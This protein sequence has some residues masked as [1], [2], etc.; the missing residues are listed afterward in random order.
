MADM[1][2]CEII[3]P[4]AP[5][6]VVMQHYIQLR[7]STFLRGCN[8]QRAGL[9]WRRLWGRILSWT[10]P[11]W[12]QPTLSRYFWSFGSR[13]NNGEKLSCLSC[14]T[15]PDRTWWNQIELRFWNLLWISRSLSLGPR[16]RFLDSVFFDEKTE[17]RKWKCE[18]LVATSKGHDASKYSR[19][20]L[21]P[22]LKSW[23]NGLKT[24]LL[25]IFWDMYYVSPNTKSV[26]KTWSHDDYQKEWCTSHQPLHH[27][28]HPFLMGHHI[29]RLRSPVRTILSYACARSN[30]ARKSQLSC[31]WKRDNLSFPILSIAFEFSCLVQEK[32]PLS[33]HPVI[34]QT[35]QE[36][37]SMGPKVCAYFNKA[38]I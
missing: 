20:G 29:K 14:L 26:S 16:F 17:F 2:H 25:G 38:I 24:K 30:A 7:S 37:F 27:G 6:R 5:L 33:K 19:I 23:V 9:H 3:R 21:G 12:L 15:I 31:I 4:A 10:S 1:R 13:K 22:S 28:R 11:E 8:S 34:S 35:N 36:G 18:I 32:N